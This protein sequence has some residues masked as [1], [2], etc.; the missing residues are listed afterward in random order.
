MNIDK[1]QSNNIYKKIMVNLPFIYFFIAVIFI[2]NKE[3]TFV[4]DDR[5]YI[6]IP[7]DWSYF[8]YSINRYYTWSS[9]VLIDFLNILILKFPKCIIIILLS[10]SYTSISCLVSRLVNYKDVLIK[11]III[12]FLMIFFPFSV[13]NSAGTVS[14]TV[15][16]IFVVM[17]RTNFFILSKKYC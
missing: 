17:F 2:V 3:F 13:E 16:Y 14:T 5:I 11:N 6:K 4:S 15:N 7:I 9:R 12:C 8:S 10:A 1:V